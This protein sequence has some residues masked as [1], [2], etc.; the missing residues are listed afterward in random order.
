MEKLNLLQLNPNFDKTVNSSNVQCIKRL[1]IL[2]AKN[3]DLILKIHCLRI[4]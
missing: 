1:E 4:T 2:C 3:D